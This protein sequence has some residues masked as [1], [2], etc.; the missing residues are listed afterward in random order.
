MH[1]IDKDVFELNITNNKETL[2]E[3][4][5]FVNVYKLLRGQADKNGNTKKELIGIAKVNIDKKLWHQNKDLVKCCFEML[6]NAIREKEMLIVKMHEDKNENEK[7]YCIEIYKKNK[8][9]GKIKAYVDKNISSKE[10][11]EACF[12][13]LASASEIALRLKEN[14]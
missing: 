13:L 3:K 8:L 6:A 10:V 9:I 11:I 14:T 1:V 12:K 4:E 7:V 2:K 5:L